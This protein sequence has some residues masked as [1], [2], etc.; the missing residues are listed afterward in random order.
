MQ[1]DDGEAIAAQQFLANIR[2]NGINTRLDRWILLEATKQLAMIIEERKNTRLFIN[3]TANALQDETLI[4]WLG[5]ALKAGGIPPDALIFQFAEADITRFL[6]PA[7]SF[8]EAIK[9]LGCSISIDG[10][11]QVDDP[12]K[13]LKHVTADFAKI[14]D[15]YAQQLQTGGDTQMLKAMVNSIA[16]S[17]TQAII[18]SV[19]NASA[20]AQLWQFG[21]NYIQGRYLSEPTT[22]MDYEFTDIA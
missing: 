16:E 21:V 8:A 12:F 13:I 17:Q 4:S 14:A 9:G 11:G 20:L 2:F 18:S 7:K 15:S 5:V 19:D 22:T 10:F 1:G 3:L 6:K